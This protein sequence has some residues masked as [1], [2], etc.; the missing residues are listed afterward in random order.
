M[1]DPPTEGAAAGTATLEA[2]RAHARRQADGL[3]AASGRTPGV[4][5]PVAAVADPPARPV[6]AGP[7]AALV[8]DEVLELG[9]YASRRLPRGT[10]LRIA[11]LDG[12][13]CVQLL[14][15]NARQTA[16]R[17]NVADT[18][19]VQ[20]QA[21]L[22][23]GALLLSDLGRVLLTIVDDTSARHDCLCGP[24]HARGNAARY[25][26]GS[27]SGPTPSGRDLLALGGL[28][29]GLARVDI[30]PSINLF[31]RAAVADDGSIALD[32]EPTGPTEVVLRAEL[33]VIV[34]VAVTPHVLDDRAAY[35]GGPVRLSAWSDPAGPPP[36][37]EDAE[38]DGFRHASPER[39]RAFLN[40]D[41]HLLEVGR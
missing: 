35:T 3:A 11:D 4:V 21:Y 13:A 5:R 1:S 27:A 6:A 12:D 18:V 20:W 22:D 17:L 38:G 40:T 7:A 32:G 31:K 26:D 2:A 33:D 39:E 9:G 24:T 34:L 41:D 15:H 16:E 25:G 28:K 37:G 30:G 29:Q 36:V 14:V 8:W 23:R 19:K 10:V